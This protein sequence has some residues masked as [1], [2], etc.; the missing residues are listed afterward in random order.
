MYGQL[1]KKQQEPVKKLQSPIGKAA[2]AYTL[3]GFR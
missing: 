3:T 2:L 1:V